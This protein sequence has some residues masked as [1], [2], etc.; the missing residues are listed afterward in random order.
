V[1]VVFQ[2]RSPPAVRAPR[3]YSCRRAD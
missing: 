1:R 3:V 2:H